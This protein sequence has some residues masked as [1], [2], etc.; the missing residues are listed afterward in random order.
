VMGPRSPPYDMAVQQSSKTYAGK[1]VLA[2]T[3]K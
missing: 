1:V 2:D 3:N